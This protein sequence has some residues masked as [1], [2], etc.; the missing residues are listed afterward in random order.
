MS[1]PHA[2]HDPEPFGQRGIRGMVRPLFVTLCALGVAIS[3]AMLVRSHKFYDRVWQAENYRRTDITSA[4][5]QIVYTRRQTLR[6]A[7][8]GTGWQYESAEF[9]SDN[10][11]W[12]E[13]FRKTIGIQ[14]GDEPFTRRD[15]QVFQAWRLRIRWRTML[16][17]YAAPLLIDALLKRRRNRHH[18]ELPIAPVA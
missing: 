6:P 7:P 1:R 15:G 16:A 11:G 2:A 10:D 14:W 9:R 8:A 12:P 4:M 17:L 13:S 18:D 5:G 3:L